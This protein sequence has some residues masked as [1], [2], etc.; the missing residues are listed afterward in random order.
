MFP[1]GQSYIVSLVTWPNQTNFRHF[2]VVRMG[3]WWP[4]K[5]A[6]VHVGDLIQ[7]PDSLRLECLN[8]IFCISE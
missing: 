3:S 8:F 4:T 1:E 6:A 2:T 7:V 5:V